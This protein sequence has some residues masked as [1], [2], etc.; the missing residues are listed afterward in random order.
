MSSRIFLFVLLVGLSVVNVRAQHRIA[1]TVKDQHDQ[2]VISANVVL[3]AHDS[4][5]VAGT[6]SDQEGE[7]VLKKI[8]SGDYV[9]KISCL[10]Y[11][12]T[13][14]KLAGVEGDVQMGTVH[15]QKQEIGLDEVVVERGVRRDVDK[16]VFFP[17][18]RQLRYSTNGITLLQQMSLN[19]LSVDLMSNSVTL[20]SGGPVL[21]CINGKA[22]TNVEVVALR[23]EDILR[24]EYHDRPGIRYAGAAAVVDYITRVKESGGL[25]ALDLTDAPFLSNGQNLIVTKVNYKKSEFGLIYNFTF[26]DVDNKSYEKNTFRFPD[27]V[28]EREGVSEKSRHASYAHE[29]TLNYRNMKKEKYDFNITLKD[30]FGRTP[31]LYHGRDM[32]TVGGTGLIRVNDFSRNRG[33]TPSLD[34]YFERSLKNDQLFV[35]NL[36]GTY[37]DTRAESSSTYRKNDSLVNRLEAMVNGEKYSVIGQGYYQRAWGTCRFG[38]NVKHN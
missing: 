6:P 1:G 20:F 34:V 36:V 37:F 12:T 10:G 30:K 14:L 33:Q 24:V 5:F 35:F 21:L 3:L 27:R 16:Q 23:P 8:H 2:P 19:R 18:A 13:R 4:V 11:R 17:S 25:I 32:R 22:V 15:L 29:L 28:L 38:A 9:L 26:D 31:E 7:F